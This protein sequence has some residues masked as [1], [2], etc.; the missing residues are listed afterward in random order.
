MYDHLQSWE[1]PNIHSKAKQ[2]VQLSP[3]IK[4]TRRLCKLSKNKKYESFHILGGQSLQPYFFFPISIDKI[5]SKNNYVHF[6]IR[7][8]S[9]CLFTDK[10]VAIQISF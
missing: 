3:N 5:C 10:H 1:N 7:K 8:E 9:L 6:I 2:Y 4:E